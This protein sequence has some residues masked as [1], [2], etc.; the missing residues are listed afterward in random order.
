MI[1]Y[2]AIDNNQKSVVR[3]CGIWVDK[4]YIVLLFSFIGEPEEDN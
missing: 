3:N 2:D 1:K 4:E